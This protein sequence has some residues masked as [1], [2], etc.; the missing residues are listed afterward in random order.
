MSSNQENA[1]PEPFGPSAAVHPSAHIPISTGG[2]ALQKNQNPSQSI[3]F[4]Y[5]QQPDWDLSR[6]K[7]TRWNGNC[8]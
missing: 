4:I 7:N 1:D 6:G 3:E 5:F 2:R 8:F